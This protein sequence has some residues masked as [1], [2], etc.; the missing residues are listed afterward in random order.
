MR[1]IN[2]TI[3]G[4]NPDDELWNNLRNLQEQYLNTLQIIIDG[5]TRNG[6][7]VVKSTDELWDEIRVIKEEYMVTLQNIIE[8]VSI[9][10]R[11]EILKSMKLM[12]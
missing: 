5:T 4:R 10:K 6:D 9:R 7:I 1:W 2:E 8:G 12:L 11:E 3:T